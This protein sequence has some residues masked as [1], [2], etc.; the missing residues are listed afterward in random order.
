[1]TKSKEGR[2]KGEGVKRREREKKG[3]KRLREG[4]EGKG[5]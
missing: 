3:M 5:G 4:K 2:E 1:M